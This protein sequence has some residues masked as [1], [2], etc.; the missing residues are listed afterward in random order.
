MTDPAAPV[1]LGNTL[2]FPTNTSNGNGTGS[3]DVVGDFFI[4]LDT[5]NG[6]LYG[7]VVVTPPEPPSVTVEPASLTAYA[8]A[9]ITLS[10]T[11]KGATPLSYQWY[12][13]AGPIAGA[14]GAAL[15][16]NSIAPAD[17]GG[18]HVVISNRAGSAT[19]ATA[20]L[21]VKV[22]L[23][24]PILNPLWALPPGSRTYI[25]TDD[26]QRGLAYNKATG[27]LLLVSRT[28]G[29]RVVVLD[30][31]TGAEKHQLNLTLEDGTPIA[32]GTYA[33]NLV[34]VTDDGVVYVGNLTT[35][36]AASP[37]RLYR[38]DNDHADTVP[39]LVLGLDN[40]TEAVPGQTTGYRWG[41]TLDI[42]GA[43]PNEQIVL[44]SRNHKRFAILDNLAPGA[45]LAHAFDVADDTIVNGNFGL[46]IAFG[47]GDTVWGTANGQTLVQLGFDLQAGTGS[48]IRQYSASE[49]PIAVCSIAVDVEKGV[50]A[51]LALELPDN[52]QLYDLQDPSGLPV[53]ADQEMIFLDNPNINGTAALDFGSDRV[54]A[55]DTNNGLLAYTIQS[56]QPSLADAR[57]AGTNFEFTLN[58][59]KGLTYLIQVAS[60]LGGGWTTASETTLTG[61]STTVQV[62]LAG[63]PL[64]FVRAQVK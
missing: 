8:G 56:P 20:T 35:D 62:P 13:A 27:N 11:A 42:R 46:G 38:W 34:G 17:Q 52:V 21:T 29:N 5:N 16:L 43:S 37:F 49:F 48:L 22:P 23:N 14:T 47:A 54:F 18:Y 28:G 64:Q 12:S 15:T 57:I 33:V 45:G 55:L 25:A 50:L 24:T 58:G 31:A 63:K 44:G 9:R 26:S 59:R 7:R 41:D 19:S 30:G 39:T 36:G 1:Q 3:A 6:L 4:G 40:L 60:P 51:A 53:L 2:P 10:V 32:G 61:T